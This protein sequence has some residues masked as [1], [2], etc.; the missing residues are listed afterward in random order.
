MTSAFSTTTHFIFRLPNHSEIQLADIIAYIMIRSS[1]YCNCII[2]HILIFT[3]S[4]CTTLLLPTWQHSAPVHPVSP[5]K[6]CT[7]CILC[8]SFTLIIRQIV[9]HHVARIFSWIIT[10]GRHRWFRHSRLLIVCYLS[11][12]I[13]SVPILALFHLSMKKSVHR[14]LVTSPI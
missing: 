11:S 12:F 6:Y 2:I 14:L 5:R 3:T 1:V 7:H 13:A 10:S 4:Y 9:I 8:V